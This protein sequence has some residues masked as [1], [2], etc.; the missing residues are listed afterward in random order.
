MSSDL[1]QA[2]YLGKLIHLI[3]FLAFLV[4]CEKKIIWIIMIKNYIYLI[5]IENETLEII[6]SPEFSSSL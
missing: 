3:H 5:I 2:E 1:P 4:F 6:P